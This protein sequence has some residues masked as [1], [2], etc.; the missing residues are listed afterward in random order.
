MDR[1][2]YLALFEKYLAGNA[3]P[4]EVELIMSY[5]DDFEIEYQTTDE[6]QENA[7]EI[8]ARLLKRLTANISGPSVSQRNYSKWWMAAAAA[9]ALTTGAF[10]LTRVN[11]N[12]PAQLYAKYNAGSKT[13]AAG[14]NKALLTLG[15]GKT[16]VLNDTTSAFT[17]RQGR[18]R[19]QK[20]KNGV[21]LYQAVPSAGNSQNEVAGYNTI[22]TPK[23]GQYQVM[24]PDGTRVW[25]NAASSLKYPAGFTGKERLVELTGEGYFVVTKNKQMPFKVKFNNEE[26]EVLGTHFDIM[27]YEE[28]GESRTTLLEGSV[29][30][31]KGPLKKILIPG[32]QAI[33]PNNQNDFTIKRADTA[34][35]L[36]WKEGIF[37]L[38]NTSIHQIMRQIAR[39]YDVDVI[40]MANAKDLEDKIYGGR[41]SKSNDMTEVLRN[42]ELTG[43]IH[44][45]V[46]GRRVMV[47]Q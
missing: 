30:I 47:M 38:Q 14:S 6:L 10:F 31:S 40:Y 20:E 9:L 29:K 5:K 33:C 32:D 21:L 8:E 27:A 36:A 13:I 46:D 28:E 37:S 24:L 22:S 35:V 34:S 4:E 7:R 2:Q 17:I 41:V 12:A 39:W 16:I 44:F 19:I 1:D 26:V 15:N 11:R 23:G 42:L 18:I 43:T 25:L 3:T 45:K